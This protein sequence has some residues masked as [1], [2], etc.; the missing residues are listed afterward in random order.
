MKKQI[1]NIFL[2][3]FIITSVKLIYSQKPFVFC[4]RNIIIYTEFPL[5]L[6]LQNIIGDSNSGKGDIFGVL[7]EYEVTD[8]CASTF[9]AHDKCALIYNH[10]SYKDK[11]LDNIELMYRKLSDITWYVEVNSEQFYFSGSIQ[12]VDGFKLLDSKGKLYDF[13]W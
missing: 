1:K 9:S 11:V 3:I 10:C 4:E 5:F 13:E 12:L 8:N 7:R 2:L 6:I